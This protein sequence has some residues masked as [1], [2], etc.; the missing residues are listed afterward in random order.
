MGGARWQDTTFRLRLEVERPS[1][2]AAG[3]RDKVWIVGWSFGPATEDYGY[4]D[5]DVQASMTVA[6]LRRT[7]QHGCPWA[8][9]QLCLDGKALRR[10]SAADFDRPADPG[11]DGETLE[12]LAVV[13]H[14][15]VVGLGQVSHDEATG[16]TVERQLSVVV[17]EG[18]DTAQSRGM[19]QPAVRE[20][21]ADASG[22]IIVDDEEGPG[23]SAALTAGQCDLG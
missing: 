20:V 12:T 13:S 6:D 19:H 17:R 11:Q 21:D 22:T 1:P 9:D 2:P 16:I 5:V 10:A 8:V 3:K 15:S 18:P 4:L 14:E 23:G 7:I